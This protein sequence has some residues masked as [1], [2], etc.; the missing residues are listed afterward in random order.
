MHAGAQSSILAEMSEAHACGFCGNPAE[1]GHLCTVCDATLIRSLTMLAPL[2]ADLRA[3]MSD[4]RAVPTDRIVVDSSREHH[5]PPIEFGQRADALYAIPA[6]WAVSWAG[7]LGSVGPA[8]LRDWNPE[9][10]VRRIPGG[11][12]GFTAAAG[13]ASWLIANHDGIKLH[14]DAARYALDVTEAIA[15]EARALGYRPRQR[16]VSGKRCRQCDSATLRLQWPL[17]RE[18]RLKC[19]ACGGDW[20]CGP[21]LAKMTMLGM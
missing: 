12:Q 18:P 10:R 16:K 6:D 5:L 14:E 9:A 7:V 2:V 3:M 13:T 15:A 11:L 1:V 19:T 4:L 20:E 17:D 8:H 21:Q